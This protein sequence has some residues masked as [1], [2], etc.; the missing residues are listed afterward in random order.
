MSLALEALPTPVDGLRDLLVERGGI[1]VG[2]NGDGDG[3]QLDVVV[4]VSLEK[5][6]SCMR[7]DNTETSIEDCQ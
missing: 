3:D 7:E 2:I 6:N 4:E 5:M 1:K